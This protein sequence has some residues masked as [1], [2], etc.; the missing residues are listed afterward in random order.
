MSTGC[1]SAP[2]AAPGSTTTSRSTPSTSCAS[3]LGKSWNTNR[4]G[5]LREPHD[6]AI[7]LDGAP[8]EVLTVAPAVRRPAA[9]QSLYQRDDRPADADLVVRAP[10]AAGP[11]T[12]GA[13][14][15]SQGA[16]LVERHRQ[17]F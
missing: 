8:V 6:V 3:R 7:L 5:G 15:V 4:I 11:H 13:A 12:V 16:E 10:V 2:A 17:P 9:T 14:F 1:R